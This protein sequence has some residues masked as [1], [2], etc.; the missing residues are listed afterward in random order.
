MGVELGTEVATQLGEQVTPSSGHHETKATTYNHYTL[1]LFQQGG[2]FL[3]NAN[4]VYL[5]EKTPVWLDCEVL[6]FDG[7]RLLCVSVHYGLA[8]PDEGKIIVP[9]QLAVEIQI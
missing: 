7:L 4:V 8:H 5:R 9:E 2:K 3:Q 1:Q 6:L